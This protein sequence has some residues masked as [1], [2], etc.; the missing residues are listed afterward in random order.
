MPVYHIT[1]T[2]SG[3]SGKE[4]AAAVPCILEEFTHRPWHQNVRSRWQDG[5]LWLEGE[6]DYDPK[7]EALLDE[8]W[9]A[10][11]ACLHF[12]GSVHFDI[13]SVSNAQGEAPRA[14]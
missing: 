14:S 3:L 12:S 11:F 2:C 13:V 6:S 4:G 10:V 5:L 7:G 1:L 9:D 8:F